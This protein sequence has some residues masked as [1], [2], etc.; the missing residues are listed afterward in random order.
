MFSQ[1]KDNAVKDEIKNDDNLSIREVNFD[2]FD[3]ED[4]YDIDD[5]EIEFNTFENDDEVNSLSNEF[6]IK[7]SKL[8]TEIGS[9]IEEENRLNRKIKQLEVMT[10]YIENDINSLLDDDSF[11]EAIK[12]EVMQT[13][14]LYTKEFVKE[15]FT[16]VIDTATKE[17]AEEIAIYTDAVKEELSKKENISL[18]SSNNL[19]NKIK[20][21]WD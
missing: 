3:D 8:V 4:D 19:L 7:F 6:E 21:I 1:N 13:I 11:K 18:N 17:L 9:L 15:K 12:K 2:E 20:S 5:E 14:H 10:E 16:N